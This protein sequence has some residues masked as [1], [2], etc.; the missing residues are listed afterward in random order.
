MNLLTFFKKVFIF[1]LKVYFILFILM[2]Q[3]NAPNVVGPNI[4]P[5]G[6]ARNIPPNIA[7]NQNSVL[8]L[9]Q[10]EPTNVPSEIDIV[11]LTEQNP[12]VEL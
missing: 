2:N 3:V 4:A 9:Q 10:D 7:Q 6:I 5:P 1:L 12:Y 8:F 11:P